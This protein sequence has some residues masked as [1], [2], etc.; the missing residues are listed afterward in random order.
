MTGNSSVTFKHKLTTPETQHLVNIFLQKIY[1]GSETG[2]ENAVSDVQE[3]LLTVAKLSLRSKVVKYRHHISNHTRKKWF[4]K[5]SSIKRHALRKVANCKR[6]NPLNSDIRVSYH[7]T[8]NEYKQ[9]LK[10]KREKFL[11]DKIKELTT[12]Q[13]DSQIKF[14]E[15]FQITPRNVR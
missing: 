13:N 2:I 7:E 10:K 5:E 3:I 1:K 9:L 4:D 15:Y 12:S 8:L 14:L 6:R 11:N